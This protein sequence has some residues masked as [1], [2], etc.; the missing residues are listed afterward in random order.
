MARQYKFVFRATDDAVVIT[1][2]G[3]TRGSAEAAARRSLRDEHHRDPKKFYVAKCT[4][5][6]RTY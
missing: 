4:F 1:A 5:A 3:N 2:E 6:G